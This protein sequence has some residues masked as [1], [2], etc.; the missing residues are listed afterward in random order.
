MARNLVGTLPTQVDLVLYQG[1]DTYLD[2]VVTDPVSGAPADLTGH[3]A[4]AQIR[5]TPDATEVLADFVATIEAHVIHLHLP[6]DQAEQLP[7]GCAAWDLQTTGPAG[8]ITTL[9]YG[10]CRVTPQ[11]TRTEP[12]PPAP[13]VQLQAEEV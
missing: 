1:D 13:P 8:E 6:H 3:T 12:A 4:Q 7:A 2:V 10:G 5:L 9:A 11:V